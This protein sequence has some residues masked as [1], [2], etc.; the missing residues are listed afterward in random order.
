MDWISN[1]DSSAIQIAE[2]AVDLSLVAYLDD[3]ESTNQMPPYFCDSATTVSNFHNYSTSDANQATHHEPTHQFTEGPGDRH[4][5]V[6]CGTFFES[7]LD[8]YEV[9]DIQEA[10]EVDASSFKQ[11]INHLSL[12]SPSRTVANASR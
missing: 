2:D 10:V 12:P 9:N 1:P 6:A 5:D 7:M 3:N 8:D 4:F 11:I